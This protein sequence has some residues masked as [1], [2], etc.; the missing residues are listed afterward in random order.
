M[1]SVY[2]RN[3]KS[4][5]WGLIN[6]KGMY[7]FTNLS[8]GLITPYMV[9]W[10]VADGFTSNDAGIIMSIGTL[11]ALITQPFWGVIVDRYQRNRSILLAS[12][13]IPAA[14]VFFFNSTWFYVLVTVYS[15]TTIFRNVQPP[16]SDAYS[17]VMSRKMNTTYGRIRSYGSMGYALGSFLGGLYL[18]YFN[19]ASMWIPVV[20]ISM[21][22]IVNIINLP[23]E[24]YRFSGKN[25]F[26]NDLSHVL[27]NKRFILFLIGC[28]LVNQTLAAFNSFFVLAF[29]SIGGSYSMA[30][31][32]LSIA[33][34]SNVPAMIM[35]SAIIRKI[36]LEKTMLLASVAYILRWTL[37]LFIFSPLVTILIQVLH[38]I[39]FGF[40]YVAAVQ[41]VSRMSGAKLQA[42]GQSIFNMVFVGVSG[43]T[44]NLINGYL[45]HLGGAVLMYSFCDVSSILGA[46]FLYLIS[47]HPLKVAETDLR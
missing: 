29:K 20:A 9:N 26:W 31:V 19:I 18:G 47:K 1:E 35:A 22:C 36:G 34:L 8:S 25:E 39:S 42:T 38:G 17:I 45:F 13:L 15:V 16:V 14:L 11:V 4:L 23:A 24:S 33:S 32:A 27:R 46:V 2:H 6:L 30:G 3:A 41:Y 10:F 5:K 40:F 12:A 43:I 21:L 37:Q 28:L 7:L 44:G